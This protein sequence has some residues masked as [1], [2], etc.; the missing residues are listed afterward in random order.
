MAAAKADR[1]ADTATTRQQ[2]TSLQPAAEDSRSS[3]VALHTPAPEQPQQAASQGQT[4]AASEKDES[5]PQGRGSAEQTEASSISE[6]AE[7]SANSA[8]GESPDAA[9]EEEVEPC[10]QDAAGAEAREEPAGTEQAPGDD[11]SC[12]SRVNSGFSAGTE[13]PHATV[14]SVSGT[15][16]VSQSDMPAS[17]SDLGKVKPLRPP[18]VAVQEGSAPMLGS[19]SFKPT[20]MQRVHDEGTTSNS[21]GLL[22]QE[23]L[24]MIAEKHKLFI[25]FYKKL[26]QLQCQPPVACPGSI[27]HLHY[28]TSVNAGDIES[29][30]A[31]QCCR[32]TK[33]HASAQLH[34]VPPC[35]PAITIP[36]RH[37]Q[38]SQARP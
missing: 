20:S 35:K 9:G 37:R 3:T 12:L 18:L 5:G 23:A 2:A 17:A 8:A 11:K 13:H 4:E 15:Q 28:S 34:S 10:R 30:A 27:T 29:H 31:C 22:P 16:T 7:Q 26:S 33:H 36:A 38:A 21:S 6:Q 32:P 25:S 14:E 24:V 19:L 1:V